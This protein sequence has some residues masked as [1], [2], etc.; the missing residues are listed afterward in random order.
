MCLLRLRRALA[1]LGFVHV[2]VRA[3][4]L[5]VPAGQ[6]SF[7]VHTDAPNM[8]AMYSAMLGADVALAGEGCSWANG[9]VPA[10]DGG[11]TSWLPGDL[12]QLGVQKAPML[13]EIAGGA[14]LGFV[15]TGACHRQFL[16]L[17]TRLAFDSGV[18]T[19]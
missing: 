13:E 10:A 5:Y 18:A 12:V 19:A 3:G 4:D 16:I 15:W 8:R 11:G 2:L 17:L 9:A 14:E 1:E 6:V 7:R